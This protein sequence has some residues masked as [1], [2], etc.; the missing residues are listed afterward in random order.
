MKPFCPFV[1]CLLAIVLTTTAQHSAVGTA[2]S[3]HLTY[4]IFFPPFTARFVV[5]NKVMWDSLEPE[6]QSEFEATSRKWRDV[7]GQRWDQAIRRFLRCH[8]WGT[9]SLSW[10]ALD[11]VFVP[12]SLARIFCGSGTYCC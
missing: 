10:P 9:K 5:M 2:Y 12:F 1:L 6:I 7:Y 8:T 11:A 3:I 4:N